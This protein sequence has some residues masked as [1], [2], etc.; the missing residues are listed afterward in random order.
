[1]LGRREEI[2]QEFRPSFSDLGAQ[3]RRRDPPPEPGERF[4]P[5]AGVLAVRVDQAAVQ[6]EQDG[7][8]TRAAA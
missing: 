8:V 6:V 1:V 5:G 7:A 3:P 4:A 2:P